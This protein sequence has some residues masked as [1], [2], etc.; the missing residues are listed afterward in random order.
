MA[1]EA[2]SP[3]CRHPLRSRHGADVNHSDTR[4]HL[5][6]LVVDVQEASVTRGPWRGEEV[7]GNIRELIARARET[8]VEVVFV[9]HDGQPGDDDEPGLPG[10][11][12]HAGILPE[13]GE[14]VVRKRNN[15]AFRGTGL[16]AALREQ[17]IGT[18]MVV[19]IQTEYC[20][21]TTCRVAF[22]LGFDVLVPRMGN[23]TFDN[24][25]IAASR[26]HELVNQRIFA[27][28]FASV[29]S[30]PEALDRLGHRTAHEPG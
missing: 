12:L 20:V 6:L 18:L 5:A 7:L 14:R 15:S 16:A 1:R 28:R 24:G 25:D 22:E 13:A 30:M 10:W 29:L 26:I 21:D 8:G 9:Q 23:T 4:G 27:G 11:E 2:Y 17:K 19:G 3:G